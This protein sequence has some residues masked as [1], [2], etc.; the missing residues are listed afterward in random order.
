MTPNET[1]VIDVS[2]GDVEEQKPMSYHE[3]VVHLSQ[4]EF[5]TDA[6][7]DG[8][9][10]LPE[11]V[12]NGVAMVAA[13]FKKPPREVWDDLAHQREMERLEVQGENDIF[14]A[15]HDQDGEP[16]LKPVVDD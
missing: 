12:T 15:T 9:I 14:A 3:S 1:P 4:Q 8:C 7:E 2:Q 5:E 10:P 13:I 11:I 6:L 16:L